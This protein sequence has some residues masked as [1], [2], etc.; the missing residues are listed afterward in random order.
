MSRL[1]AGMAL[2]LVTGAAV[3]L[4]AHSAT[5]APVRA[6]GGS[7]IHAIQ[8]VVVIMQENR[9]FDSYFG[10][11]PGADG[12]PMRRGVPAVCVP[13]PKHGGCQRPYHDSNDINLGG[14][15]GHADSVADVNHGRMDGFVTEEEGACPEADNSLGGPSGPNDTTYTCSTT[16]VMGYHDQREIPNYWAYARN[17]VLHDHMF[18]SASSYSAV[19]HLYLVSGWS[20]QCATQGHPESCTS[21]VAGT[22]QQATAVPVNALAPTVSQWPAVHFDWT[23][24]TYL[25]HSH[26]VSWGYYLDGGTVPDCDDGALT[27]P[28]RPQSALLPGFWNPLPKFDTVHD[29]SQLGNVQELSSFRS[30]AQA[31][32]LPAVSWVIPNAADSEHPNARISD[33]QAYVTSLIN[34]LMTGPDWSSTA[35]FLAWD[36]WGGF[37]DHVVP[38]TIDGLGYGL[39]VPSIVISPYARRGLVDH[40]ALSFDAYL[41]FIEDDF[42]GGA[43]I[44]PASDGR[45]DPRPDVRERA[46][47]LGNLAADFDFGQAPRPPLVLNPR[48]PTAGASGS[49]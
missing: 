35:I 13:D 49:P 24:L 12:I 23:D 15:H 17:F 32:T 18:E 16:D 46:P 30:A 45:W 14:P 7:G 39:R 36:D 1:H 3:A 40:Q 9:S 33:G 8:H 42:I 48:P 29:D 2:V 37:Y 11:Y 43:R 34:L 27:C 38:P 41:K 5:S 26:G 25:L 10:T 22:S 31:G 6:A 28:P 20:A 19:S 44:D 47:Q 21:D 4:P